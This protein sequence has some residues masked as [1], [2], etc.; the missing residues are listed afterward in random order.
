MPGTL[1]STLHG[2]THLILTS[3]LGDTHYYYSHLTHVEI[4]TDV[5]KRPEGRRFKLENF[6]TTEVGES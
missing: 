3:T 4:G 2:L 5:K 1:P 6:W